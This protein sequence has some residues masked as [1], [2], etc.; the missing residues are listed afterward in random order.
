MIATDFFPVDSVLLGRF[1]VLFF[2]E[3]DTRIV[4]VAGITTDPTGVQ[5]QA[6][7]LRQP[8]Q[9][10]DKLRS[11]LKESCPHEQA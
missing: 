10:V 4:H 5:T 7:A 2:I 6:A 9:S 1:Y 8:P 3:V 11:R